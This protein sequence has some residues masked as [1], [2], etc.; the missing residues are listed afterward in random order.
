MAMLPVLLIENPLM[1]DGKFPE[2]YPNA[3]LGVVISELLDVFPPGND[4]LEIGVNAP[5]VVFMLNADVSP[6]YANK[7]SGVGAG[8]VG[9][10]GVGAGGLVPPP[11]VDVEVEPPPP[12]DVEINNRRVNKQIQEKARAVRK[13]NS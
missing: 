13:E 9:A 10:G 5:V 4:K 6:S 3:P 1:T 7:N 2:T 11:D 8:G 12:Q